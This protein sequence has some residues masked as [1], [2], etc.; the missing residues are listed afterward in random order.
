MHEVSFCASFC[1]S[2]YLVKFKMSVIHQ[3][4]VTGREVSRETARMSKG[5]DWKNKKTK[6]TEKTKKTKMRK[7]GLPKR[8]HTGS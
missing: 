3:A 8:S 1:G 6:K 4:K 2:C 7:N 5:F